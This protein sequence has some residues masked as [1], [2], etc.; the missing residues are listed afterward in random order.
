MTWSQLLDYIGD[1]ANVTTYMFDNDIFGTGDIRNS[2]ES[3]AN[4]TKGC[5]AIWVD[6]ILINEM[7]DVE[8]FLQYMRDNNYENFEYV[9]TSGNIEPQNFKDKSLAAYVI[10][11]GWVP[12]SGNYHKLWDDSNSGPKKFA[13]TDGKTSGQVIN[14]RKIHKVFEFQTEKFNYGF[15]D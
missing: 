6:A 4:A 1:F 15:S 11:F 8:S 7:L 13:P 2:P 9:I 12:Q 3:F 10:N 5:N 14:S